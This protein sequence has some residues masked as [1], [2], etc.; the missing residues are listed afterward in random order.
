[1]VAYQNGYL[2]L[3]EF[4]LTEYSLTT[5]IN[6]LNNVFLNKSN[7]IKMIDFIQKGDNLLIRAI[8]DNNDRLTRILVNNNNID[9]LVRDRVIKK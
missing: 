3:V 4:L 5:Q 8:K 9:L 6:Q 1:M 7:L 2:D